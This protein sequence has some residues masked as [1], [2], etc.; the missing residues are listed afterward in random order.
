MRQS[1]IDLT[2][3]F[4]FNADS[5]MHM[6]SPL[7]LEARPAKTQKEGVVLVHCFDLK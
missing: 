3:W 4:F 5:P 2:G 1:D 6:Y 7:I